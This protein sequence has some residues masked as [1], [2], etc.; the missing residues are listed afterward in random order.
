M[1]LSRALH[2]N[3]GLAR[4]LNRLGELARVREDHR[5][6]RAYYDEALALCRELGD[7]PGIGGA[8]HNLA[9]VELHSGDLSRSVELFRESLQ[10]FHE[11][12][13]RRVIAFC[14][15]GLG[16]LAC[17]QGHPIDAAKLLS[18]ADV[19]LEEGPSLDPSEALEQAYY[20]R[21]VAAVRATLEDNAFSTAWAEGR[22]MTLGQAVGYALGEISSTAPHSQ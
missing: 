10:L 16:G 13:F 6:A 9:Y 3:W 20:R 14:L 1:M 5:Q 8:L 18:A 11:L 22:A 21:S 19:I 17:A 2:D 15:V 12:G 7:K 4:S